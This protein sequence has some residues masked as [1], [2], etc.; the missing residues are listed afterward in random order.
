MRSS[1]WVRTERSRY[2]RVLLDP[3]P[4]PHLAGQHLLHRPVPRRAVYAS[5]GRCPGL[6]V[7]ARVLQSAAACVTAGAGE[8]LGL[9]SPRDV[10]EYSSVDMFF[11]ASSPLSSE[12]AA[13]RRRAAPPAVGLPVAAWLGPAHLLRP[14]RRIASPRP[15]TPLFASAGSCRAAC[16]WYLGT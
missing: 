13:A 3:W 12:R 8:Q 16:V 15:T 5:R 4:R 7:Y 10:H 14:S 2:D 9:A 6:P 1:G 11:G